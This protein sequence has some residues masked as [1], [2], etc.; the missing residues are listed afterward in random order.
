MG[1]VDTNDQNTE[2]KRRWAAMKK[3]QSKAAAKPATP[4]AAPKS[5]GMI[6]LD[7]PLD[8]AQ[9]KSTGLTL[10][11]VDT[12]GGKTIFIYKPSASRTKKVAFGD[13]MTA[14]APMAKPKTLKRK[15]E[16]EEEEDDDD[17]DYDLTSTSIGHVSFPR[18]VCS[19]SAARRRA[20]P[21]ASTLRSRCREARSSSRMCSRSP[22]SSTST[23]DSMTRL[24]RRTR[25]ELVLRLAV[26]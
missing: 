24:T 3:A 19:R 12:K 7:Q 9:L 1:I 4:S 26:R 2:I 20:R 22:S 23:R 18:S 16:E 17:D 13:V 11:K 21:C 15:K 5:P 25:S 14:P 6:P 8:E 10:V